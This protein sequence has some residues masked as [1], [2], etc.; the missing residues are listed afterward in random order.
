MGRVT[1]IRVEAWAE[2]LAE[3][4]PAEQAL[5]TLRRYHRAVGGQPGD[6]LRWLRTGLTSSC[7]DEHGDFDPDMAL[8]EAFAA[9]WHWGPRASEPE[10]VL[11][12]LL[13]RAAGAG[14]PT[15]AL[16][17]QE[18]PNLGLLDRFDEVFESA[19]L[20]DDESIS[21][22]HARRQGLTGVE[23]LMVDADSTMFAADQLVR[24]LCGRLSIPID[25]E[26]LLRVSEW[27]DNEAYRTRVE[28]RLAEWRD[29]LTAAANPGSEDDRL[30]VQI[31]FGTAYYKDQVDLA[32][33][34]GKA[35]E[36]LRET[37]TG[38]SRVVRRAQSD[39]A[40]AGVCR[41]VERA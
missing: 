33:G 25:P 18:N 3:P 38:E 30:L 19:E 23:K 5:P 4:K 6:F 14:E 39:A 2:D 17:L 11:C 13:M 40:Q 12:V 20:V 24:S 29:L 36:A 8:A 21:A 37:F 7:F 28:G 31:R 10:K 34:A 27:E 32:R 35:V 9:V 15:Q 1:A 41:C 26:S 22:F 16:V